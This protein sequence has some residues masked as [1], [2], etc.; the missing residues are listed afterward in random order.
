[1]NSVKKLADLVGLAGYEDEEYE[2]NNVIQKRDE[3]SVDFAAIF[4][5]KTTAEWLEVLLAEDIWCG[6]V[7]K[8]ADVEQDP[9][10]AANEMLISYEHP[11]AG[12]VRTV[13]IPVKFQGTPGTIARPAPQLGEHTD[14][15]LRE[16][17]GYTPAEIR[18]LRHEQAFG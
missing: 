15:I 1:M 14:E 5:Q 17:G 2:S 13:G 7:Y 3:I 12:T 9:Q 4:L 10:I 8:Y 18:E 16:F 11:T 6:P